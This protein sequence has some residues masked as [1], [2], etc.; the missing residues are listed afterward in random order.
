M[1]EFF[2]FDQFFYFQKLR[3]DTGGNQ[4]ITINDAKI[5]LNDLKNSF[6]SI[7]D[8]SSISDADIKVNEVD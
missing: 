6:S 8:L 7:K 4:H 5:Q 1:F 3:N 2:S